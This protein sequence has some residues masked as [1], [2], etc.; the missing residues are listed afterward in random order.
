MRPEML[1][2]QDRRQEARLLLVRADRMD[3]RADE[4]KG[5]GI[6]CR[7]T[8][9]EAFF[10]ENMPLVEPPSGP[11][12]FGRPAHRRPSPLVEL[13]RPEFDIGPMR[14]IAEQGSRSHVPG[15]FGC[16]EGSDLL[17]ESSSVE[18]LS[19]QD[20]CAAIGSL[21]VPRFPPARLNQDI[22]R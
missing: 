6:D 16:D 5:L 13:C 7:A 2:A 9:K 18:W 21:F 1:A 11:A 20:V 22:A 14:M 12:I 4:I 19:S 17:A 15:Q 10:L 3:D 8:G